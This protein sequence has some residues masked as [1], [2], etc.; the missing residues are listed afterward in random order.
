MPIGR[1]FFPEN[2]IKR[3][4]GIKMREEIAATGGLVAQGI[5]QR[6]GLDRHQ[7]Q[8]L[9]PGEMESCRLLGLTRGREMDVA[10]LKIDGGTPKYAVATCFLP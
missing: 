4:I 2:G 7:K 6:R 5:A 9:D 10:V 1:A 8:S 3:Q